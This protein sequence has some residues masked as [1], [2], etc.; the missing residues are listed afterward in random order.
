M[1]KQSNMNR[2]NQLLA[3]STAFFAISC[4]AQYTESENQAYYQASN[5][6]ANTSQ[7]SHGVKKVSFNDRDHN[8]MPA[9]T[10]TLPAGYAFEGSVYWETQSGIYVPNA[11]GQVYN[12]SAKTGILYF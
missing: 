3:L 12:Q 11:H 5:T 9:F 10:L 6:R 2:L 4:G 8:N 1:E 7:A